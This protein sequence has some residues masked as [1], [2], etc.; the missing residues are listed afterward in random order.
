MTISDQTRHQ[1]YQRL[2]DV[3]GVNEAAT[4][5]EH[6]PVGWADVATK[7][8][9]DQ[10]QSS[11]RF[12]LAKVWGEFGRVRAD[13]AGLRAEVYE[14]VGKLRGEIRG[15]NQTLFLG[16]VGLQMT[17]ATLAVVLSRVL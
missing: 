11:T 1:L 13:I 4:L 10:L 17:G 2:E 14:E 5:M 9:L 8:D 15:Q 6:P 7:H 12:E 3:L 16:L